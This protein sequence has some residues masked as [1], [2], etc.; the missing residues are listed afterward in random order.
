MFLRSK[1]QPRLTQIARIKRNSVM[2][3][4]PC[5]PCNPWFVLLID[6]SEF[7][8]A[9]QYLSILLP[10]TESGFLRTAEKRQSHLDLALLGGPAIQARERFADACGIVFFFHRQ[11]RRQ[12]ASTRDHELA[13]EHEQLL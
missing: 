8:G 13:V 7:V 1:N 3:F 5:Y 6:K 4:S 9:Q 12:A 10:R 2:C 11:L